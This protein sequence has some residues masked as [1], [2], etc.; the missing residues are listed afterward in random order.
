MLPV[1]TLCLFFVAVLPE[2]HLPLS[3]A[4]LLPFHVLIF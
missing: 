2:L 3:L 1:T 4:S